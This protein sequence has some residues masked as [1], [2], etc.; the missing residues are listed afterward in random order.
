MQS[1]PR[2]Q[3]QNVPLAR[4]VLTIALLIP[5][6]ATA[7]ALLNAA[8]RALDAPLFFDSVF[9]AVAA[10]LLGLV[11]GVLVGLLSN[12]AMEAVSG[13]PGVYIWFAPVNASTAVIVWL[14]VHRR[15][16]RTPLDALL[17]TLAVTV[18]NAALGTMT[19]VVVYGG[20]TNQPIDLIVTAVLLTGVP[21]WLS[22]FLARIP[23]NLI[24]KSLTV[25]AAY[26]ALLN[27]Q[28]SRGR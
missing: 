27:M 5:A 1:D 16:L 17:C 7:N 2:V 13:F 10:A 21:V 6:F 3:P 18:V 4:S 28:R 9:T 25:F 15:R 14:F 22:A 12:L 26:G 23:L 19:V 24:D 11:P 20:I 8:V